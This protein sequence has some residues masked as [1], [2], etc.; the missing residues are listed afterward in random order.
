[1]NR[2]DFG[3]GESFFEER[4][5]PVIAPLFPQGFGGVLEF[6]ERW[7]LAKFLVADGQ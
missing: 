6:P 2:G 4:Q 5:H 3:H 7:L 1:M